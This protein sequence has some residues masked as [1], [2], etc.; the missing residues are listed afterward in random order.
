MVSQ[1]LGLEFR[2][3]Q[4]RMIGP[5]QRESGSRQKLSMEAADSQMYRRSRVPIP[6]RRAPTAES[7]PVF[8]WRG[9]Q[10]DVWVVSLEDLQNGQQAMSKDRFGRANVEC[11]CRTIPANRDDR[12][13][14]EQMQDFLG[15]RQA[16]VAMRRQSHLFSQSLKQR[17]S[18]L[19]FDSA[20]LNRDVGLQLRSRGCRRV[21][22]QRG[23]L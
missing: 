1:L 2:V 8:R 17:N 23:N 9:N 10:I 11:A 13:L 12:S 6:T 19:L 5:C 16:P 20:C 18:Q 15:I 4:E 14:F 7:A 21:L 3:T 22:F